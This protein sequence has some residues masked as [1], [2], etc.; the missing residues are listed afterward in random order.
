MQQGLAVA[1]RIEIADLA[2]QREVADEQRCRQHV[3]AEQAKLVGGHDVP[4][5][6]DGEAQDEDQRRIEPADAAR[7]ETGEAEG[8]GRELGRNQPADQEAGDHEEDVDAHIAR[9]QHLGK[10]VEDHHGRDGDGPQAV[11]VGPVF[12]GMP[13]GR[14]ANRD[15]QRGPDLS[16]LKVPLMQPLPGGRNPCP[17][18][19]LYV[20]RHC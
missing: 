8:A 5:D 18:R 10:R 7:I 4:A 20:L 11:D 17:L 16:T 3:P 12:G 1:F 19:V 13:G 9:A 6:P 15:R 14:N 2:H